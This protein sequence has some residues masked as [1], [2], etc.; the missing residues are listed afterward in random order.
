MV[1]LINKKDTHNTRQHILDVIMSR[2]HKDIMFVPFGYLMLN[3]LVIILIVNTVK[4]EIIS[5]SNNENL[6]ATQTSISTSSSLISTSKE[7]QSTKAQKK[8]LE[9]VSELKNLTKEA[10]GFLRLR[11]AVTGSIP[12]TKFEWFS[13]EAP[14]MEGNDISIEF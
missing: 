9:F 10:G 1:A 11:C 14:L 7:L 12:A 5:N 13:N 6:S 2:R 8:T 3:S 4:S